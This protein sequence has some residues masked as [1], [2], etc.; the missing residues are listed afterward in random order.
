MSVCNSAM[1]ISTKQE[2]ARIQRK[3]GVMTTEKQAEANRRNARKSTGPKTPEGKA[4]VSRNALKHGLLSR[5]VVLPDENEEAFGELDE[6]LRDE[7]QPV[8]VLENLLVDRVVSGYWRL[9]RLGRV[10]AGIFAWERFEVRAERA[11][12]EAGQYEKQ[13]KGGSIFDFD[14]IVITDEK[15]HGEALEKAHRMRLEQGDETAT[16][17]R[18]FAR[19]AEQSN[20]F[21]KLARY[22]TGID[23]GI[24]RALNK[25][26]DLQAARRADGHVPSPAVIDVDVPGASRDE[27]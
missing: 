11:E 3:D 21:S 4:L 18:T 2:S 16:L 7:L 27:P 9:I 6:H 20:A 24:D 22:E 14:P 10:E 15:K 13:E 8:G 17:G 25:L 1:R 26:R 12:Q 23:R 5:Q 19:D